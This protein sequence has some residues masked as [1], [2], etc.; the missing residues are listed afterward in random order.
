MGNFE[1]NVCRC[2]YG[3]RSAQVFEKEVDVVYY[4][5]IYKPPIIPWATELDVK[6]NVPEK[7]F[8]ST[9]FLI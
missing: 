8:I 6:E 5:K 1:S 4:D 2:H 7:Y 9:R 3:I